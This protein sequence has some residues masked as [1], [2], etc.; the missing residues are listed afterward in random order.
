MSN[1]FKVLM[2]RNLENMFEEEGQ[3][4]SQIGFKNIFP[5]DIL[6]ILAT[7]EIC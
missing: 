7:V 3:N 6:L 2:W 1:E 5:L 4:E